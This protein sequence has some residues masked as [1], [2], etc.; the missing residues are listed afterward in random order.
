[1]HRLT[2]VIDVMLTGMH[3]CVTQGD[4]PAVQSVIEHTAEVLV[5]YATTCSVPCSVLL[6]QTDVQCIGAFYSHM[7]NMMQS[8]Q[9][10]LGIV[11]CNKAT[12]L[13]VTSSHRSC[14]VLNSQGSEQK[15]HHA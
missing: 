5:Q 14:P 2:R 11:S 8:A 1:M 9:K 6:S 4:R 10:L 13:A 12:V 15:V 7:C 3:V